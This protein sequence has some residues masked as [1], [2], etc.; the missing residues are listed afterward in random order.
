MNTWR[1]ASQ[2]GAMG[3]L[4]LVVCLVVVVCTAL[5]VG[6]QGE[7]G[8][9]EISLANR[10]L[11]LTTHQARQKVTLTLKNLGQRNLNTFYVAV[12]AVLTGKVAYIGAH[13]SN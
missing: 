8:K 5:R 9:W 3:K 1:C 10:Q 6:A 7:V 13:V 11:D 2:S 12:D 4:L